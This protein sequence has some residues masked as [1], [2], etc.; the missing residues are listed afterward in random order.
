M[1]FTAE[2]HLVANVKVFNANLRITAANIIRT[3]YGPLDFK[4]LRV[5]NCYHAIRSKHLKGKRGLG[6]IV[7][8]I[9]VVAYARPVIFSVLKGSLLAQGVNLAVF[10]FGSKL[11]GN[12]FTC[13]VVGNGYVK[14]IGGFLRGHGNIR[15]RVAPAHNAGPGYGEALHL[16]RAKGKLVDAL[17]VLKVCRREGDG[18]GLG[19]YGLYPGLGLG[20]V[21]V[22]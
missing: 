8:R 13:L 21:K 5:I 9:D 11:I 3:V 2:H 22:L 19:V 4:V 14:L 18:T 10:H 6:G 17:Q 20:I 15:L 1:V 12:L 7:K 16:Q